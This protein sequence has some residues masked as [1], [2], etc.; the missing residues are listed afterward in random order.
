MLRFF[1][2]IRRRL[3]SSGKVKNYLLYAIG[4]ILLVVIGILIALQ[5]NNWN[6]NRQLKTKIDSTLLDIREDLVQ[7]TA[8]L[9]QCLVIRKQDLE[10][11][12]KVI[13]VLREKQPLTDQVYHDLSRVMLKRTIYL[14]RDGF[15][16]LKEIGLSNLD[17]K[18]L[19]NSL[20]KYYG[21]NQVDIGTEIADDDFEFRE[22]WLPYVREKF[23]EWDFDKVAIPIDDAE[24]LNDPSLLTSLKMNLNNLNGT[25]EALETATS[26]AEKLIQLIDNKSIQ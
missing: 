14:V 19:R 18:T 8:A 25:I 3:R 7:D 20:V 4:E 1:R 6:G 23:K 10:A 17:D 22:A 5:I 11:Q 15:D 12:K 26:S 21:R 2:N 24:I 16:L 13:K 9:K